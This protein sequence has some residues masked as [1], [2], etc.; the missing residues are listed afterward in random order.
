MEMEIKLID[1]KGNSSSFYL[2]DKLLT[3]IFGSDS[4][5]NANV[6]SQLVS[7]FVS[8]MWQFAELE[9]LEKRV[10]LEKIEPF[11]YKTSRDMEKRM[12]NV[13]DE[14]RNHYGMYIGGKDLNKLT[15]FI[16]GYHYNFYVETGLHIPLLPGFQEFVL[17]HY[18]LSGNTHVFRHWSSIIA[19]FSATDEDAF[20]TFY[21]LLDKFREKNRII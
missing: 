21:E 4:L 1:T 9:L 7:E 15:T 6:G 13:F 11:K 12:S 16:T 14:L 5:S 19:F 20:D 2:E 18:K 10:E 8:K 17:K 3:G